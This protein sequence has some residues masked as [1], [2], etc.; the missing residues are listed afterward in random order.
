MAGKNGYAGSTRLYDID[1][2]NKNLSLG[3]TWYLLFEFI[4]EQLES[5]RVEFRL[6]SNNERSMRAASS[7]LIH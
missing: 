3:Y 5:E 7:H 2:G 6:D 4:F 1:N